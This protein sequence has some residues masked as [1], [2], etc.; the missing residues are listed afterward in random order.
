MYCSSCGERKSGQNAACEMCGAEFPA[1]AVPARQTT[2]SQPTAAG[3]VA[4]LNPVTVCFRCE[5][6][7]QGLPYFSRGPHMAALVAATLFTLPVAL[8]AGGFLF[9]ALRRDHR[10]CPRCGLGW[11]RFGQRAVEVQ[12][13]AAVRREHRHPAPVG[14]GAMRV[15]SVLLFVLAA[16]LLVTGIAGLEFVPIGLGLV[17]GGGGYALRRG[18]NRAREERRAAL[19]AS[20]Q[21][22][23]LKL[24]ARCN[25]RLTVTEVAATLGWP[26]TRAE[27]VLNSLDD[28]WRVSSEVTDEGIIVYE[29][30][31]LMLTSERHPE[32]LE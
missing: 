25:G 31:E 16:I 14:E 8:G 23:V 18:A 1:P 32:L 28:G 5:F 29:F 2:Q 7:G 22:P 19:I 6:Q 27:K 21:T 17:A 9:Y 20:L 26:L 13:R 10:I 4:A 11:G 24:A 30:R 12:A 15:W 3:P